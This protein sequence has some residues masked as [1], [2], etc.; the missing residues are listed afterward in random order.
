MVVARIEPKQHQG[1]SRTY[2]GWFK[3]EL[4]AQGIMMDEPF[5]PHPSF[6]SP[7]AYEYRADLGVWYVRQNDH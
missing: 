2:P 6:A 3:S 7:C 1:S 4:I 5:G